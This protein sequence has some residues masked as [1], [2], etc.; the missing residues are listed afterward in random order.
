MRTRMSWRPFQ[1]TLDAMNSPPRKTPLRLAAAAAAACLL[2]TGCEEPSSDSS[3]A[4]VVGQMSTGTTKSTGGYCPS[5][6]PKIAKVLPDLT[7]SDIRTVLTNPCIPFS[8][9]VSA[10]LDITVK[11]DAVTKTFKPVLKDFVSTVD[12]IN[13]GVTCAYET[14]NLG[15]RI[16]QQNGYPSSVGLTVVIRENIAAPLNIAICFVK[17]Q[18]P[19]LTNPGIEPQF[20]P[21]WRGAQVTGD[22]GDKFAMLW[23][24]STEA[25]CDALQRSAS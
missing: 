9:L 6:G 25:V 23:V 8:G 20:E 19:T 14:D 16:Y 12:N 1:I 7:D 22:D 10:V 3:S 11:E 5:P 24:G 13:T 21:C 2:L 4:A 18:V 17:Q 15:I